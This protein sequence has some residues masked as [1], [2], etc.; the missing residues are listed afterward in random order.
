MAEMMRSCE[1]P[2]WKG[3][4]QK[5]AGDAVTV[6]WDNKTWQTKEMC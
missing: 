5:D 6:A 2:E 3:C 1:T 4:G